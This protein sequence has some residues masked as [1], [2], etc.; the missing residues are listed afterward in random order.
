MLTCRQYAC[1]ARDFNAT[2]DTLTMICS[3]LSDVCSLL[4]ELFFCFFLMGSTCIAV[5]RTVS[6]AVAARSA[7][8]MFSNTGSSAGGQ[9]PSPGE[10]STKATTAALRKGS[11]A[12]TVDSAS[13]FVPLLNWKEDRGPSP[14]LLT[15]PTLSKSTQ[16]VPNTNGSRRHVRAAES[17]PSISSSSD[18]DFKPAARRVRRVAALHL[19]R[20]A[21]NDSM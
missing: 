13:K 2:S 10:L 17:D 14:D 11:T 5:D 18:A 12:S 19:R 16:S 21:L 7:E 6:E 15:L 1:A 9:L 8:L 20:K 4:G 3:V